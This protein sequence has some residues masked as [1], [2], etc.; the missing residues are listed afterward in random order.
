MCCCVVFAA[1]GCRD[2][3]DDINDDNDNQVVPSGDN[4]T[5][6]LLSEGL[7]GPFGLIDC[8]CVSIFPE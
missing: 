1:D 8:V 4:P 6:L 2:D 3:D 7:P 5:P